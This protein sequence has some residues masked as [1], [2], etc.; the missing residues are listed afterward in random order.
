MLLW[1][2]QMAKTSQEFL[3]CDLSV[4][5]GHLMKATQ[6]GLSIW[7]K[8]NDPKRRRN[9]CFCAHYWEQ[10]SLSYY[11]RR[12]LSS[13][14]LFSFVS[15]VTFAVSRRGH[16]HAWKRVVN[17]ISGLAAPNLRPSHF[18]PLQR[19]TELRWWSQRLL[20]SPMPDAAY[21]LQGHSSMSD[22]CGAANSSISAIYIYLS[23]SLWEADWWWLVW[24]LTIINSSM[25]RNDNTAN[26]RVRKGMWSEV[27]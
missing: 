18:I 12:A 22:S 15:R 21:S 25:Q 1:T 17:V 2:T 9:D 10:A 13:P 11:K 7:I 14:S 23:M 6:P 16:T 4:Y 8:A 5:T 26:Q 27:W 3:Y 20:C 19:Y 24:F